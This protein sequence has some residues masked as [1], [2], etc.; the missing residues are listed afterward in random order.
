M[1]E[2]PK[3][4]SSCWVILFWVLTC[5]SC[6]PG[7]LCVLIGVVIFATDRCQDDNDGGCGEFRADVGEPI[8][9][10]GSVMAALGVVCLLFA[11]CTRKSER[12]QHNQ[13]QAATPLAAL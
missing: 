4:K 1:S 7:I 12:R 5:V 10:A 8:I 3:Y 6:V 13:R 2:K 9:I 11:V